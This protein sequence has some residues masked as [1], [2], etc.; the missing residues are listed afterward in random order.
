MSKIKIKIM[1]VLVVHRTIYQLNLRFSSN[2]TMAYLVASH[3]LVHFEYMLDGDLACF[4]LGI[5]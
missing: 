5:N 4:F 3:Y 2:Y 1:P